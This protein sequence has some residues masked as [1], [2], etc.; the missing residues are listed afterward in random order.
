MFRKFTKVMVVAI[1]TLFLLSPFAE[2]A[3]RKSTRHR[4]RHSSRVS[5]SASS[6]T[7]RA[8]KRRSHTTKKSGATSTRHPS[9]K[10]R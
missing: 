5:A 3:S 9:T 8:G 10:P 6:K 4:V 2:A 1:A 7:H